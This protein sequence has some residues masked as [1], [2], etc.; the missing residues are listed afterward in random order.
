VGK[1]WFLVID[2]QF[3]GAIQGTVT[4]VSLDVIFP[5]T[6]YAWPDNVKIKTT[7]LGDCHEIMMV[8]DSFTSSAQIFPNGVFS[9][10]VREVPASEKSGLRAGEMAG[11]IIGSVFGAGSLALGEFMISEKSFLGSKRGV[12]NKFSV[13]CEGEV[14]GE[15]DTEPNESG[16]EGKV[17]AVGGS[18]AVIQGSVD[19]ELNPEVK[20]GKEDGDQDAATDHREDRLPRE[21]SR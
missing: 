20:V 18:D 12:G 15:G 5:V 11:V 9:A 6:N 10:S 13:P 21:L 19:L 3:S 2:C 4:D 7:E 16:S 1:I 8:T 17:T 14:D